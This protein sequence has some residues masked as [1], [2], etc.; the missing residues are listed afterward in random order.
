MQ[1][2]KDAHLLC[3]EPK[4]AAEEEGEGPVEPAALELQADNERITTLE[5][6]VIA[7]RDELAVLHRAFEEFKG[8]F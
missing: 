1:Y 2:G 6:E 7:L 5:E 4:A 8:Q 3:G